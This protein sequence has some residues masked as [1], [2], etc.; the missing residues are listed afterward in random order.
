MK[1]ETLEKLA[2]YLTKN[3]AFGDTEEA[4]NALN[5]MFDE[6]VE[7]AADLVEERMLRGEYAD[8]INGMHYRG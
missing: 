6:A 7:E 5:D 4:K 1:N 3:N 2:Y 8:K